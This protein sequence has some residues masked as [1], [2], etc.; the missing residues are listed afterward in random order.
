M[1][2]VA[3]KRRFGGDIALRCSSGRNT[4]VTVCGSNHSFRRLT[5][6]F[7]L[8]SEATATGTAQRAIPTA[9]I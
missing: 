8:R 4:Q 9:P 2:F 1:K 7:R 5:L 3:R 6:R